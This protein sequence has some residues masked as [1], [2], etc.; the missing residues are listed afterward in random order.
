[1]R[2]TRTLLVAVSLGIATAQAGAQRD[3]LTP[4][5][6]QAILDYQLTLPRASSLITAMQAMSTYVA[7]LPNQQERMKKYATMTPAERLALVEKDPKSAA[8][9]RENGLTA[10]EYLAGV[11]ALRM[12]LY[13][14]QGSPPLPNLI[15]SPA[16][17]AF[18]K[19]NY[20][21]LKSKLDAADGIRKP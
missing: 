15:A 13:L 9:L 12:A 17:I 3:H 2:H 14:S 10:R 1:M 7:S 18:A 8:I 20:A 16:N 11:P 5:E 19:T 6:R 4:E 21:E